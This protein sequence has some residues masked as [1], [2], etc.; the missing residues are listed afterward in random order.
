VSVVA[1]QK[2]A[3]VF[4]NLNCSGPVDLILK[5]GEQLYMIDVKLARKR[6]NCNGWKDDS[7]R[8]QPPTY[9]LL[10]YPVGPDFS[11]WKIGWKAG[12]YPLELEN[13]W[14]KQ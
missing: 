2:G 3:E 1:A 9:P 10:V 12:R 7:V 6:K 14:K 8:V 11:S 13:F 4:R 5:V